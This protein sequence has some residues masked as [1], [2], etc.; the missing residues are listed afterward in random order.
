MQGWIIYVTYR[1]EQWIDWYISK[2]CGCS[3]L[4]K[5][6]FKHGRVLCRE[7]GKWS[8]RQSTHKIKKS[9]KINQSGQKKG[10]IGSTSKASQKTYVLFL[11]QNQKRPPQSRLQLQILIQMVQI[12][13]RNLD[14]L[15]GMIL[16]MNN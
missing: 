4:L 2:V 5:R 11:C 6:R 7:R 1:K 13:A 10:R 12:T 14:V 8:E 9:P 15:N 3:S 16:K